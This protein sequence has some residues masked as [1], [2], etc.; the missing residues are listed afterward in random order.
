MPA[1]WEGRLA[2][3]AGPTGPGAEAAARTRAG[4]V[5][6]GTGGVTLARACPTPGPAQG[7]A[8]LFR[9][10]LRHWR[11]APDSGAGTRPHH[12]SPAGVPPPHSRPDQPPGLPSGLLEPLPPELGARPAGGQAPAVLRPRGLGWG[13]RPGSRSGGGRGPSRGSC[14]GSLARWPAGRCGGA[15][16]RRRSLCAHSPRL[17]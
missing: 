1:I 6:M 9:R 4:K 5:P 11:G 10:F 2:R 14:A 7:L 16:A 15:L 8:R 13:R 12:Q 3:R 17:T